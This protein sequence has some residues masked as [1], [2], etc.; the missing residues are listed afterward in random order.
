MERQFMTT[1]LESD[2]H[3]YHPN[4][5]L[6]CKRPYIRLDGGE[7]DRGTDGRLSWRT[8]EI[9]R[10]RA[11]EMTEDLIRDHNELVKP[12]DLV[13]HL[14]DFSFG[15]TKEVAQLLRRLNG[16]YRFIWGNHDKALKD[17]SSIIDY[18]PD[19][20][21]RVKFL[22][23]MAEVE[24]EDKTVVLNHY[25]MRVWNKSHH[26][27]WHL[28][29]HSHGT[30]PDDPNSLSFDVGI[31]CHQYKPIS[32]DTVRKIMAKKTYTPIDHHGKVEGGGVGMNREDYAKAQRKALYEGLKKEFG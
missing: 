15:G 18:Y 6:H 17:F 28:Y 2:T 19:L 22:G 29:G 7:V 23:N 10:V 14:G 4:I 25:A 3:Y 8:K 1:W 5:I 27:A 11:R 32:F 30:L 26:D 24:I 21:F 31:D 9:G 16:N 12:E 13:Y 20:Q